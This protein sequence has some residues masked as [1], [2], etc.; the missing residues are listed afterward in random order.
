M[1]FFLF[2]FF[3]SFFIQMGWI[4]ISY[5]PN[6]YNT[7]M[8]KK[9]IIEL[10]TKSNHR[11]LIIVLALEGYSLCYCNCTYERL[12]FL[13]HFLVLSLSSSAIMS[14]LYVI[15]SK[16]QKTPSSKSKLFGGGIVELWGFLMQYCLIFL[17]SRNFYICCL[18]GGRFG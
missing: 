4:W 17:L 15:L 14:T 18:P 16:S 13:C 11:P 5:N 8:H 10:Q 3:A 9:S 7:I 12:S 6:I 2:F 1:F